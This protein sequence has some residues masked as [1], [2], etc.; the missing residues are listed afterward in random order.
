MISP[1][2][3][4]K[5]RYRLLDPI[6]KGGMAVVYRAR[7]ETLGRDVAIKFLATDR[8]VGDEASARFLREARTIARLA[9]PNIMALYDV[10]RQDSWHYLV[11]EYIPGQD[12]QTL[13]VDRGDSLP[14]DEAL[15]LMRGVLAGLDYAHGQGVIHRDIKPANIM[16]T[17]GGQVKLTDFGLALTREEVRLTR[18]GMLLGTVLYMAP[19]I[20]SGGGFDTRT[21]LYA[22]GAV[23][24]ELVT[25]R[26]PFS[27]DS[28]IAIASLI[29]NAPVTPPRDLNARVPQALDDVI[30]RLLAKDPGQRFASTQ[31]VLDALP[32]TRPAPQSGA[33]KR[34]APPPD[35]RLYAAQEDKAAA[36]EAERRRV[37]GL[38]QGDVIESLN[39]LLAQTSAFEMSLGRDQQAR[40]AL[41]VLTSL[42]RQAIQQVRD[43]EN[44][45]HPAALETLGLE[46]ALEALADQARRAHGLQVTLA[47]ERLPERPNPQIELALLRL[48]QDALDRATRHARAS[49]V[50][51]RLAQHDTTLEF[52]FADNG[53]AISGTEMLR[54]VRQRIE[55]LGGTIQV[56]VDLDGSF[57]LTV[58]FALEPPV[59]LTPREIEALQ[60]VAEGLSNK[61]IAAE[62][63]ISPRTVNYHLDNVYSKLAVNSRTEAAIYALRHGFVRQHPG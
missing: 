30:T 4:L 33:L 59:Y 61:E 34:D 49:Q 41:S 45:L 1:P 47:A 5:D 10:D 38:L 9:H 22:V 17:P 37:A 63:V 16:I 14:V 62:L 55:Q 18:E 13:L 27:G 21:D 28:M 3:I 20:L 7:D 60:L 2:D 51:I 6:G 58:T 43:L 40:M 44:N 8:L 52:A 50:T 46:P 35:I 48:A 25:G 57:A 56:A 24:Y 23:L 39:L 26:V 11:L 42:T 12:I 36:L 29:L 15:D 31:D 19:E 54:A 32:Q 53:T